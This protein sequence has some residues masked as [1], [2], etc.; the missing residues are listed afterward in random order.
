MTVDYL[1]GTNSVCAYLSV[2]H[3]CLSSQSLINSVSTCLTAS[4][5][6]AATIL[7]LSHLKFLPLAFL[8]IV[9]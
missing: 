3:Q 2:K 9:K 8:Y 6:V 5:G 7:F 4:S 1:S